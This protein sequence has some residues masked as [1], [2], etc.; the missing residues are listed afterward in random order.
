MTDDG[1]FLLRTPSVQVGIAHFIQRRQCGCAGDGIA[2]EGAAK[3]AL[4]QVVEQR[5]APDH[6]AQR[7]ATGDAFTQQDQVWLD[8]QS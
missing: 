2:G 7:H 4:G 3:P 1:L 5:L 8:T 6:R